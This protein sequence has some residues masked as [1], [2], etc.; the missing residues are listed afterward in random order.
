MVLSEQAQRNW[1]IAAYVFTTLGGVYSIFFAE[2]DI[3]G[4]KGEKHVF[5]DVQATSRATI[6]K[7]IYGIERTPKQATNNIT[8]SSDNMDSF[9]RQS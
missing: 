7:Y 3:P 9:P 5:S 4:L 6:D 8:S 1:K 2:Y